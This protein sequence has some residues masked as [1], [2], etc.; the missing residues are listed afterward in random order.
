MIISSCTNA[1]FFLVFLTA[2]HLFKI[3]PIFWLNSSSINYLN[4]ELLFK[5]YFE[6][7]RTHTGSIKYKETKFIKW[8]IPQLYVLSNFRVYISIYNKNVNIQFTIVISNLK[9]CTSWNIYTVQKSDTA[10]YMKFLHLVHCSLNCQA[11][12]YVPN[13]ELLNE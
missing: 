7:K 6:I 1:G 11:E 3:F 5:S 9:F 2:V 10:I 8:M 13:F 4:W 12:N